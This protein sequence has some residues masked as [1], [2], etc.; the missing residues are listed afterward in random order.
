MIKLTEEDRQVIINTMKINNSKES[1]AKLCKD[2]DITKQYIYKLL[3]N[4]LK[5]NSENSIE[6]SIKNNDSE[7][8]KKANHIIDLI[9]ARIERELENGEKINISQLSTTLGILY[10]KSR[11]ENNLS[12]SNNSIN[13]NIKVEK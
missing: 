7:F 2:Y 6:H 10:D 13:I 5:K 8:T 3:R 1:V 9:F 4:D 11:L 12:T